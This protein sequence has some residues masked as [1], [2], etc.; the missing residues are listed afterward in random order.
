VKQFRLFQALGAGALLAATLL[1]LSAQEPVENAIETLQERLEKG[2][3]SLRYDEN[4]HGYL[5]SLLQV[6]NIPEDSQVLPF[7]K[8]SFQADLIS[9]QHPRAVYFNADVS[10]AAV[11][12][13]ML[14]IIAN[15][16]DGGLSFY[17]LT[18]P[19]F[20]APRFEKRL[21]LCVECHA[22]VGHRTVGW[23]VADVT[24]ASDGLPQVSDP[25]QPFDFTDDTVPFEKRWGG[26]YVTGVTGEMRHRGNVTS[27][28]ETPHDLPP[29]AGLNL[30]DLAGRFE[31][32]QVLQ[33]GSD[34]V[35]LLTL[36]HQTGFTN[37]AFALNVSF[38]EE[39]AQRLA[40][41]MTFRGEVK[42]P[43]PVKGSSSFAG[44]FAAA[45]PRDAQGRSLR[46]F[47]L[48]TRL[49]RYPLS[50]MIYS[51]AFDALRPGNKA[52][53]YRK[54]NAILRETPEGRAA[55]AIAAATKP[56]IPGDW[57]TP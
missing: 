3:V 43:S 28:P 50:Y 11:D 40:E 32:R 21:G 9:P 54:L 20:E 38:A 26:W 37:R 10:V 56:D 42:L 13:D 47:D 5:R 44:N 16:K 46:D 15:N 30:T 23:I 4:G 36:E 33:P 35:A 6:L 17:T 41:Y 55:I 29:A 31:A 18:K 1:P 52:L 24:T 57:K 34:V 45:G 39:D 22:R 12:G 48:K 27:R 7:S 51:T 2:E 53:L 49:F 8:S 19:R 14:E 25:A